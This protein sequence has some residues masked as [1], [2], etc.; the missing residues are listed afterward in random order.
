MRIRATH[1]SGCITLVQAKA[2]VE[3]R[4]MACPFCLRRYPSM[5]LVKKHCDVCSLNP[6]GNYSCLSV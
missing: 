6:D 5:T 4:L 3:E 2:S 1:C